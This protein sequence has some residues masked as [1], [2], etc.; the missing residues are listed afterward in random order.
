MH[1]SWLGCALL[2]GACSLTSPAPAPPHPEERPALQ[3]AQLA[4]TIADV[5]FLIEETHRAAG[6][7]RI[8]G[9]HQ[10][11]QAWTTFDDQILPALRATDP[12]TALEAE[13]RFGQLLDALHRGRPDHAAWSRLDE[14]LQQ[15]R[16]ATLS[17]D[18][19]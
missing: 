12:H 14:I 16:K 15:R 17:V 4:D 8:Q 6:E 3:P 2:L 18:N 13:Y 5:Q 19:P 9:R 1:R 10:W 11:R 7:D